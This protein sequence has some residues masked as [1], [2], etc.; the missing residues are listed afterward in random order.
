MRL[1]SYIEGR[2]D[3]GRIVPGELDGGAEEP[4]VQPVLRDEPS[5]CTSL[6][7]QD[8][9]RIMPSASSNKYT[10]LNSERSM[11]GTQRDDHSAPTTDVGEGGQQFGTK[12]R[13]SILKPKAGG[14]Q[15]HAPGVLCG[16][17]LLLTA[18]TPVET[19]LH[20]LP[21]AVHF[22]RLAPYFPEGLIIL[23]VLEPAEQINDDI[24]RKKRILH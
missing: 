11:C 7:R 19:E 23:F 14:G 2:D 20:M 12:Y 1:E 13:Y 22:A 17:V 5:T 4:M 15:A 8:H 9:V 16:A 24:G 18:G 10:P 21:L 6:E 3:S